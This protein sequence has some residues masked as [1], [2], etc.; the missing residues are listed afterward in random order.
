MGKEA[1]VDYQWN[2]LSGQARAFLE[3]KELIL[4]VVTPDAKRQTH[5]VILTS[6]KKVEVHGNQLHLH[7][8]PKLGVQDDERDQDGATLILAFESDSGSSEA[9]SWAR[10]LTTPPPT[11]AAKL[12]ITGETQLLL[13]GEFTSE[14]LASAIGEAA[15]MDSN[16]PDLILARVATIRD[17]DFVLDC[18]KR[19]PLKPPI[20]IIYP[21]GR[22]KSD[23]ATSAV[24]ETAIRD[25]LR[26]EGLI[27]TKVVSVSA[28]LTALRFLNRSK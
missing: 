28:T 13:M 10:K 3:S 14:E 20:W 23:N 16:C 1:T 4:R 9:Q 6:V 5:K 24:G 21:K 17:L 18:Y 7:T 25:A 26:R 15:A 22:S 8:G 2:G 11:L 12:G 19:L 27:D